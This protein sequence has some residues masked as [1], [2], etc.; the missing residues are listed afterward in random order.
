V[1]KKDIPSLLCAW[2]GQVAKASIAKS[3]KFTIALSGGSLPNNLV[4]LSEQ[5]GVDFSKWHVFFADERCVALDSKD[6]NFKACNDNFFS[7]V[8]IPSDQI[9][10]IDPTLSTAGAAEAYTAALEKVFGEFPRFDLCL[11]GMGPDGHTCSLFPGH[12]LLHQKGWCVPIED[13]PKPPACRITLTRE[14]VNN[15]ALV[16]F[17]AAGASKVNQMPE[18]MGI[19]P[20][21]VRL[22][23][24]LINPTNGE[25]HWWIDVAA[26]EKLPE[27]MKSNM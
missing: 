12:P 24:S 26:G 7:K 27:A 10:K 3:G 25:L 11:L 14:V 5:D 2:V 20:A 22:P 8:D 17:V 15:S 19:E 18:M 16:G 23:A 9:Y 6:S 4:A 1:E 21:P 13:S